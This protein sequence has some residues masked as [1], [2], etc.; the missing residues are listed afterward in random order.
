MVW[1]SRSRQVDFRSLKAKKRRENHSRNS[2]DGSIREHLYWE[3]TRQPKCAVKKRATRPQRIKGRG[4][5]RKMRVDDVQSGENQ[6]G[7][8]K[9][10]TDGRQL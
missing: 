3:E 10:K 8:G 6:S 1:K 5:K 9:N 4:R 7:K 2:R